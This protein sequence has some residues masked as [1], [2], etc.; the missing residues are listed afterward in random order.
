[1]ILAAERMDSRLYRVTRKQQMAI[2]VL[3]KKETGN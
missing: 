2:V 1:M 3:M